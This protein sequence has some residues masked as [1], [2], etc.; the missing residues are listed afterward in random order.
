MWTRT[1]RPPN[2][3]V[4]CSCAS[5]QTI[6]RSSSSSPGGGTRTCRRR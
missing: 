3:K 2:R 6:D 1:M 4:L 5:P